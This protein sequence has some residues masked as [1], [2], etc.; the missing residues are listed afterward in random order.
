MMAGS[1][2]QSNAKAM[3]SFSD[4]TDQDNPNNIEPYNLL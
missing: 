4:I 1:I 2:N 3:L